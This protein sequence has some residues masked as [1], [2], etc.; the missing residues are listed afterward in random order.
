[1]TLGMFP[2]SIFCSRGT[3]RREASPESVIFFLLYSR[4]NLEWRSFDWHVPIELDPG[5]YL[6]R[7]SPVT[8]ETLSHY[9][10]TSLIRNRAPL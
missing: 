10:G 8:P 7:I 6:F 4:V 3:P 5:K 9:K 2:L 1:M